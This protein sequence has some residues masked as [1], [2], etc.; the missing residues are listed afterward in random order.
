MLAAARPIVRLLLLAV[1]CSVPALAGAQGAAAPASKPAAEAVEQTPRKPRLPRYYGRVATVDQRAALDKIQ[2]AYEPKIQQLRDELEKLLAARDAELRA[3][4]GVEQQKQFDEL[5]V[6]A[7]ERRRAR[8]PRG[9]TPAAGA[10]ATSTS[11]RN[12][13]AVAPPR[14]ATERAPAKP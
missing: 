5:V 9:Q 6:A 7:R 11:A 10:P 8:S 4:L 13:P 2:A 12:A 3:A 14:T 1:I